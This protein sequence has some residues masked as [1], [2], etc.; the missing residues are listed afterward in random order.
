MGPCGQSVDIFALTLAKLG[1]LLHQLRDNH[2]YLFQQLIDLRPWRHAALNHPVEQ[3]LDSPGQLTQ[4]QR[5]D[6]APAAFKRVKGPPQFGQCS[7]V[8]RVGYPLGQIVMQGDQNL[9]GLFKKDFQQFFID[10][11][12]VYRGR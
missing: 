3:I 9:V 7:T 8:G 10:C 2:Q 11:C 4:H 5:P 1:K 12:L 6:H